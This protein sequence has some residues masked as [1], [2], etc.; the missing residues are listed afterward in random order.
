MEKPMPAQF[1][2]APEDQ[3][4]EFDRLGPAHLVNYPGSNFQALGLAFSDKL[5]SSGPVKVYGR[6]HKPLSFLGITYDPKRD[7]IRGA[8][9]V[10]VPR[11]ALLRILRTR[12]FKEFQ[13][14]ITGMSPG[15]YSTLPVATG[16]DP[17]G[18]HPKSVLGK[19]SSDYALRSDQYAGVTVS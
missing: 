13:R 16:G 11:V 1:D 5:G 2:I 9:G 7:V 3:L 18:V 10:E 8:Q 4:T 6:W 19:Y 14:I 15:Q 12:G 17:T